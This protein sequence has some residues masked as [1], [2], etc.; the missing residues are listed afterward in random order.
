E[1]GRQRRLAAP[2]PGA[3]PRVPGPPRPGR[4]ALEPLLRPARPPRAGAALDELPGDAGLRG[5]EPSGGRLPEEGEV[6][7]RADVPA[8]RPPAA[9]AGHRD[10]GAAVPPV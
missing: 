10:A 9:A 8:A 6:E 4:H 1:A 3:G 5:A 2:E 7:Q